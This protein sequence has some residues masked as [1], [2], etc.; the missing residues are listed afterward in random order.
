MDNQ[1]INFYQ[2]YFLEKYFELAK[3]PV[4]SIVH[5][6][7]RASQAVNIYCLLRDKGLTPA[8]SLERCLCL[9]EAI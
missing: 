2:D 7:R 5:A 8:Y 3:E 1:E 6:R 9:L 4:N